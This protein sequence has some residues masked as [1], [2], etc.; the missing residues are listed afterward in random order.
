VSSEHKSVAY[1]DK[2]V[3]P[4]FVACVH[5]ALVCQPCGVTHRA[6]TALF[7]WNN[8]D[9]AESITEFKFSCLLSYTCNNF[10]VFLFDITFSFSVSCTYSVHS[11]A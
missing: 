1:D 2:T 9:R 11:T 6:V 7:A 4:Q 10:Q 8:T 3:V 5:M